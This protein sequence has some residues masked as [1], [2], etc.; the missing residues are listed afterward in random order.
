MRRRLNDDGISRLSD[1]LLYSEET[2]T[3]LQLHRRLQ[4]VT[5]MVAESTTDPLGL[6]IR[7]PQKSFVVAAENEASK[8]GWFDDLQKWIASKF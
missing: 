5:M 1:L 6:E 7:S 8:K 4:L 3:N 2:G